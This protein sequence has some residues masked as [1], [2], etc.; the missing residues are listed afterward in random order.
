MANITATKIDELNQQSVNSVDEAIAILTE[1]GKEG[2]QLKVKSNLREGIEKF[3]GTIQTVNV[4]P[5]LLALERFKKIK[6]IESQEE[7]K[8]VENKDD[9]KK[10]EEEK[11]AN[12]RN[13][14]EKQE[15]EKKEKNRTDVEN[16]IDKLSQKISDDL[17][18]DENLKNKIKEE[19]MEVAKDGK[20]RV[21][22]EEIEI[23]DKKTDGSNKE[24]EIKKAVLEINN[25]EKENIVDI[26]EYK[27]NKF[28]DDFKK[29]VEV[30]NPNASEEQISLAM[31][32]ADLVASV[33]FSD[34]GI[35]NQNGNINLPNEV[36]IGKLENAWTDLQGI[37]GFLGKSDKEVADIKEK[38][39]QIKD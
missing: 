22:D 15:Q 32:E 24:S 19:V 12:N 5:A 23:L 13:S 25:W 31:K 3:T 14:Q 8:S 4:A 10:Q 9:Q 27:S 39:K 7:I 11:S 21:V 29:N 34:K 36:S 38:Y 20:L 18:G 6:E 16:K 26:R 17:K 1:I 2:G 35:E 33:Y 28:K 37:T 30:N